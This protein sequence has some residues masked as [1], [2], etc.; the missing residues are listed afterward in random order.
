[1]AVSNFDD[2]N[3]LQEQTRKQKITLNFGS[4]CIADEQFGNFCASLSS[5]VMLM[6][7]MN[8][9]ESIVLDQGKP[10]EPGVSAGG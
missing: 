8:K 4:C 1:M 7:C 3:K 10:G 9:L 2:R 5:I 6:F